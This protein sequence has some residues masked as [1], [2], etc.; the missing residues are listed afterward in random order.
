M[1]IPLV[2]EPWSSNATIARRRWGDLRQRN[3]D[4]IFLKMV[5]TGRFCTSYRVVACAFAECAELLLA[6]EAEVSAQRPMP[7]SRQR[8]RRATMGRV[9]TPSLDFLEGLSNAGLGPCVCFPLQHGS[10]LQ[11]PRTLAPDLNRRVFCPRAG[12]A[13]VVQLSAPQDIGRPTEHIP[14]ARAGIARIRRARSTGLSIARVI[15]SKTLHVEG[16]MWPSALLPRTRPRG[17]SA[18]ARLG[19][20]RAGRRRI[21]WR[22]GSS[23]RRAS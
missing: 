4:S 16:V 10:I 3:L 2:G 9:H 12:I 1:S 7:N 22:R 15:A 11:L 8:A 19:R 14:T 13:R 17:H 6:C 5:K 23:R 18:R 20:R 21:P